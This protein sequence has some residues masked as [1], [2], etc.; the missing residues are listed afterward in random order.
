MMNWGLIGG[1]KGSQI[2][3]PHRIASRIDGLFALKA[4]ALDVDAKAGRDFAVSLGIEPTRAYGDWREMLAAEKEKPMGERL[5]LVTVATPNNTHFE[6]TKAFLQAGFNVLCEKPLTMTVAEADE[7]VRVA[8]KSGKICAVNFGYSGYPMAIQAREMIRR[9]DL[10]K[11]H[12]IVGEF[13]HGFH[14]SGED[15]DNP[16]LRWRYDP[17]QAGV[18]AIVAD[19]G[20][21]VFH[22]AEFMLGQKLTK[23]SAQMDHCVASRQ[24]EDDA[25][26]AAR[27]SDGVI[28]RFWLSAVATGHQHGFNVRVFG[29]KGGLRWWQEQPNQLWYSQGNGPAQ[30]LERGSAGLY[31]EALDASRITQGHAEG[32]LIAFANIYRGIYRKISGGVGQFPSVQDGAAMVRAVHAAV[33]SGVAQ[34]K[35]VSV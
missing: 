13:A 12:L 27:F 30:T 17:A 23:L 24:L 10:G 1:G 16:R 21:H 14:A 25:Q 2:G 6:I 3:E 31:P 19:V 9:G 28:G 5:D 20:V 8:E 11:V 18:S 7:L 26:I 15:A 4:G 33:A 29:S 34:G 35:W 32:M 22:M